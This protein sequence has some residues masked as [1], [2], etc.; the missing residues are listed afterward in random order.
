MKVTFLGTGTSSGVPVVG[1]NCEVCRSRN[2]IETRTRCSL[3]IETK[4]TRVIIDCGPDFRTQMLKVPFRKIDGVLL[5][6]IHYDHVGGLDD[7]RPFCVFGDIHVMADNKTAD[8]LH[9]TMPYVFAKHLYPGVPKINLEAKEPY[10]EFWI[11]D[12]PVVPFVVNHAKLPIFAYRFGN[13][14]YIT[15]MKTISPENEAFVR[16]VD[17]L[18]VNALRFDKPHLSHML[19][20]EAIAFSKRVGARRV[21]FTHV[22]HEI[23]LHHDANDR[24]P[25]GFE[26]AYDGLQIN[27]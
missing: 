24:L 4:T 26:F 2:A 27:V 10:R 11:G 15:D 7:L 20:D 12:I 19:V 23:G 9:Q 13:F 21:F 6:H 3:M 25:Q 16:G 17:T 5:T 14:A 8:M 22:T 1:C 18:V